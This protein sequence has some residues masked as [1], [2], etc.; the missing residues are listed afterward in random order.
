[1]RDEA[2]FSGRVPPKLTLHHT[3][4][5]ALAYSLVCGGLMVGAARFELAT[6]C[7]P[8]RCAPGLRHAPFRF[9]TQDSGLPKHPDLY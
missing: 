3:L 4:F 5:F 8:C 7:T 6:P 2:L 9:P 1:M